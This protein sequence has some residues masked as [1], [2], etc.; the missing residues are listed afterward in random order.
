MTR[1]RASASGK[2]GALGTLGL[3]LSGTG[4]LAPI[5]PK[6]ANL[7]SLHHPYVE[8][9]KEREAIDALEVDIRHHMRTISDFLELISSNPESSRAITWA[10]IMVAALFLLGVI[11]PLSFMP[12][13]SAWIPALEVTG[14]WERLVSLQ[15]ILLMSVSAVFLAA[16]TMFLFMNLGMRYTQ[17]QIRFLEKFT[18][19]GAYSQ[20]YEIADENEKLA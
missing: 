10:L 15:G 18:K 12:T 6:M 9:Q 14:F 3:G 19:I 2:I 4:M 17:D 5:P 16:I 11:Y 8:L 20:Y 13:P 1:T 7:R